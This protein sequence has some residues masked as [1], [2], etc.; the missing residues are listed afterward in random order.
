MRLPKSKFDMLVLSGAALLAITGWFSVRHG[1]LQGGWVLAG[2]SGCVAMLCALPWLQPASP[3]PENAAQLLEV[4][5]SGVHRMLADR[6]ESVTW[7][8]LTEVSIVTTSEGP[9]AEDVFF[10]L[11]GAGNSGVLVPQ[12]L[13]VEHHLLESLQ[14]RLP[15]FNNEAVIEAMGC[16][17][18]RR[19]VVWSAPA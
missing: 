1:G 8:D 4:D 15:E 14:A 2:F 11:Q 13:A 16:T 7:S 9:F 10:M 6:M 5:E 17:D 12:S 3:Q 19:F 18:D